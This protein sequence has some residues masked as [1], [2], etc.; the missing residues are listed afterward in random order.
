M[1]NPILR[2]ITSS[3]PFLLRVGMPSLDQKP[4]EEMEN[5]VLPVPDRLALL[6]EPAKATTGAHLLSIPC[7]AS[8]S[9]RNWQRAANGKALHIGTW[10]WIK[11]GF[12]P[13]Q[14]SHL[15]NTWFS[16]ALD[17]AT[18]CCSFS[19]NQWSIEEE[20]GKL[21]CFAVTAPVDTTRIS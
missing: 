18:R 21:G 20:L 1:S 17:W 13:G 12:I 4:D 19:N 11:Y 16:Q 6:R 9:M 5:W 15:V 3:F 14:H 10:A 8:S 2:V 7:I